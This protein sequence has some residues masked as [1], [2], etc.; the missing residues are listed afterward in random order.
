MKANLTAHL[1]P[2]TAPKLLCRIITFEGAD[3]SRA[4][5]CGRPA[6]A[7]DF[8]KDYVRLDPLYA[9]LASGIQGFAHYMLQQY[10][11]ALPMLRD[12]TSRSPNFRSGHVWLAAT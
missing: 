12:C 3:F 1:A 5:V 7:L 10:A 11:Q 4:R 2:S 6:A 8:I 9:P